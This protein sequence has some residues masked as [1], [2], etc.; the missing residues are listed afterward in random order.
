LVASS[1]QQC[2]DSELAAS[3]LPFSIFYLE[4]IRAPVLNVFMAELLRDQRK[5]R[6]HSED[7]DV[8]IL[9]DN[10]KLPANA[11]QMEYDETME[12]TGAS[13]GRP[14]PARG[15][16]LKRTPS[17]RRGA[18]GYAELLQSAVTASIE[19]RRFAQEQTPADPA[20]MSVRGGGLLMTSHSKNK[21][22]RCHPE[23]QEQAAP[24]RK[25]TQRHMLLATQDPP[26]APRWDGSPSQPDR[27]L[28]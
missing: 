28:G 24:T 27:F 16:G 10:S 8:I 17:L 13:G 20:A 9:S 15:G 1:S 26:R 23:Y 6:G 21:R 3:I 2:Q 25:S 18:A 22:T 12:E 14:E 19:C 4:M 7:E 5:L 11:S